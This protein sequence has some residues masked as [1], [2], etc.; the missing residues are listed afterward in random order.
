MNKQLLD[1][2]KIL[3]DKDKKSLSQKCL[4]TTE[5][6]GELSKKILPFENARGTLHRFVDKKEILEE[7]IDVMLSVLSIAYDLGFDDNDIE[8]MLYEKSLYWNS[9]QEKEGNINPDK[10][11]FEIHITVK[12]LELDNFRKSCELLEVKPIILELQNN[13]SNIQDVMTSSV[14]L[15]SNSD[16]YNETKIISKG[17][18][19]FGFEVIREKI[20]TVPWH[21]K[22]P[23]KK[24]NNIE[25]PKNCYFE[26]HFNIITNDKQKELLQIL[27][28]EN[29]CHLSKNIFKKIDEENY[30]IMITYRSYDMVYEDFKEKID[31]I[32]K[33][34]KTNN[35]Q[36]EKVIIEFS[37]YDTKI[38]H[39]FN[40]LNKNK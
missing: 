15:G 13:N 29:K 38:S 7:T 3:T 35:F 30:K 12:T 9:L 31:N 5:E 28:K 25:M 37:L 24:Y 27:S 22:A 33:N 32:H 17:L 6:V 34:F 36:I 1:Y 21:P 18:T 11:P 20:E 16:A 10:I 14:F 4:K 39:D 8:E 2:I 19:K 23:S 26:T 40:W